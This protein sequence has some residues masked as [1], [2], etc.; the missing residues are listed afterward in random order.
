MFLHWC[1][2]MHDKFL[3]TD[4]IWEVTGIVFLNLSCLNIC[5]RHVPPK[6][7]L[8]FDRLHS[9]MSQKTELFICFITIFILTAVM[10]LLRTEI[11]TKNGRNCCY[12]WF[13]WKYSII[14]D[15]VQGFHWNNAQVTHHLLLTKWNDRAYLFCYIR[16]FKIWRCSCA[17]VSKQIMQLFSKTK[18]RGFGLWANYTDRVTA[19]CWRS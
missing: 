12:L 14:Q 15:E 5:A 13:F 1:F 11:K 16:L 6:H 7:Q 8:T 17:F 4:F 3:C 2:L 19:A 18:L 10:S 9:V